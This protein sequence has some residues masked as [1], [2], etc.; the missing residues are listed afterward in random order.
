MYIWFFI[1]AVGVVAVMPLYFLS[2]KHLSLQE[3]YGRERG[4]TIG[5]IS[6]VV[7]GWGFFLFWFGMW[8]SPQPRFT[9]PAF[10]NL[11]VLVPAIEVSIPIF[12][13]AVFL[14]LFTVGAWLGIEGVAKTTL[15]TA[16]THRPD[17]IAI[18][19]VYSIVRH[20]QYLGGLLAHVG[21][22]FLL[23]AWYSLL[24]TLM[25][26]VIIYVV[27]WKEEEELIKEFGKEYENYKKKVPMLVP[28][29]G[30]Q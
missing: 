10:Q 12:H 25:M 5:E 30:R 26:A 3:K 13:L 28:R 2:I 19:G 27:S 11:S 21:T 15:Y 4:I 17:K 23:S 1:C 24:S 18:E 7:S 9:F 29:R 20:P 16:E 14:P 6:G 8:V 22:S